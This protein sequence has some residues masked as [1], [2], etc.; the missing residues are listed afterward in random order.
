M[1]ERAASLL[2]PGS[3]LASYNGRSFDAPLVNARARLSGR[4]DPLAPH[5]HVDLLYPVRRAFSGIWPDCKLSSVESRLLR[6]ERADDLPGAMAPQAWVDWL[7]SAK[8]T[9]L[10]QV[11][12]H[13]L[14]D[15]V[16]LAALDGA[17]GRC[18]SDP[19]AWGA[20]PLAFGYRS[21]DDPQAGTEGEACDELYAYLLANQRRL[22]PD[23]AMALSGMARRRGEWGVAR[24]LWERLA[25]TGRSDAA[26]ALAK[27]Y[28]HKLFDAHAAL[29][30][31]RTLRAGEPHEPAHRLREVRLLSRISRQPATRHRTFEARI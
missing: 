13:N 16:S 7:V 8:P 24:A 27:L 4:P 26:L 31:T 6:F 11:L 14:W 12:E 25:A 29:A 22:L 9:A 23:A 3:V 18:L 17:I 30:L 19:V 28:E 1:F 21:K 15:L 20:N 2:P 5:R 10:M